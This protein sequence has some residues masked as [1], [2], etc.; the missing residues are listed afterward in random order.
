[1]WEAKPNPTER[2]AEAQGYQANKGQRR[3]L[4]NLG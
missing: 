4:R 1:M 3:I 2:D